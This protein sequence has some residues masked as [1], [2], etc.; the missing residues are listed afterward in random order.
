MP[1]KKFTM[2]QVRSLFESDGYTLL[3]TEYKNI[4]GSLQVRCPEGHEFPTSYN[5][6]RDG[7]RCPECFLAR[8]RTPY[9]E[10]KKHLEDLGCTLLS[11]EYT[12]QK[13]QLV[14]TCSRGHRVEKS[15][16]GIKTGKC[17]CIECKKEDTRKRYGK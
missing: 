3:S 14:Y 15:Y 4:F 9:E 11:K 1:R 2:E 16:N 13:Q 10:V 7:C 17:I 5:S 8:R 6:F 12:N